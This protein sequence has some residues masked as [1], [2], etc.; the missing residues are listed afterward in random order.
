MK[1]SGFTLIE[2]VLTLSMAVMLMTLIGVTLQFYANDM[3]ARDI[4]IRR[5]HLATSILQMLSDDLRSTAYVAEYDP[6]VLDNFLKGSLG[7]EIVQEIDPQTS[8]TLGIT[9]TIEAVGLQP[10]GSEAETTDLLASSISLKRPGLVGNQYQLQID[11]SRLPRLEQW[12]GSRPDE[13]GLVGEL[14][15]IPSDFKTVSYFVQPAESSNGVR[16]PLSEL[17]SPEDQKTGFASLNSAGGLV[18]RELDRAANKW[19]L[20]NG[21]AS[22]LNITGELIASEV[23]SIEF[24]Y[25]DGVL[26]QISWNSDQMQGLPLAIKASIAIGNA[27]SADDP[28]SINIPNRIFTHIIHIPTGR[29]GSQSGDTES[30]GLSEGSVTES[31]SATTTGPA[32]GQL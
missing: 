15:D 26:W 1:R 19:A 29:R 21:G 14:T 4:G 25:F 11:I 2:V 8:Q 30:S 22:R 31:P 20:D 16:N 28:S 18:R 12:R 13:S 32:G 24:S 3:S 23:L 9:D 7:A 5:V 6:A 17:I 27:S 10:L